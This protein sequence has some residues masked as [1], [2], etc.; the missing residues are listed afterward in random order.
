MNDSAPPGL[1]LLFAGERFEVVG[2]K[3][4]YWPAQKALIVA[5]LHLE[6]AS[7]FA[8]HGQML[9]PYD[10]LATIEAVA[11]LVERTGARQLWCL[12]DNFHDSAG[13]K[14]LQPAAR[15]LLATLT[16]RLDWHWIVGNHD[17]ALGGDIGGTVME[18]AELCG[19]ILRHRADPGEG[20]AELSGHFHPKYHGKSR[21]RT[22]SRACFVMGETRLILPAF[23]AFTGGLAADHID[24]THVAGAAAE[25]LVPT[26][27]RL[28]RFKL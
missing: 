17:P 28:L 22:V 27:G 16:A 19:L 15:A 23:G 25:A 11:A 14:R 3:A 13:V 12:G 21:S 2:G 20:R 5:D 18:E 26:Q 9:P 7:W 8:K 4:L 1:P 10:S 6:K 24:I